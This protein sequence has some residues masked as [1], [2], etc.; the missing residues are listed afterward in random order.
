MDSVVEAVLLGVASLLVGAGLYLFVVGLGL[1]RW[2]RFRTALYLLPILLFAAALLVAGALHLCVYIVPEV[3][4]I[5]ARTW[6]APLVLLRPGEDSGT[7]NLVMGLTFFGVGVLAGNLFYSGAHDAA[8]EK[9]RDRRQSRERPA[10]RLFRSSA[11]RRATRARPSTGGANPA[12]KRETTAAPEIRPTPPRSAGNG[13]ETPPGR[14]L[15]F[16][17][18]Q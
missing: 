6:A 14:Y 11:S 17:H 9:R 5:V 1:L 7:V 13:L 4:Q 12:S 10:V 16:G 8:R 18:R 3:A 2:A 15:R